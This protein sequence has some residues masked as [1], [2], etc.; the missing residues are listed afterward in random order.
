MMAL[1]EKRVCDAL[2]AREEELKQSTTAMDKV[3]MTL[4]SLNPKLQHSWSDGIFIAHHSPVSMSASCAL[5][6]NVNAHF[7]Q[8]K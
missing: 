3:T 7:L 2:K 8:Q 6:R 1:S 5:A 4:M